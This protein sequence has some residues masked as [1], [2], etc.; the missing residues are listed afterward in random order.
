MTILDNTEESAQALSES[1]RTV[2]D[3]GCEVPHVEVGPKTFA[4]IA[5]WAIAKVPLSEA[6]YTRRMIDD[7]HVSLTFHGVRC[8]R[9]YDVPEG[10]MWPPRMVSV[11]AKQRKVAEDG[12]D[13]D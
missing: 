8:I 4:M 3:S 11:M 10:R 6:E 5:T 1:L 13:R 2:F 9:C 7:E 12:S